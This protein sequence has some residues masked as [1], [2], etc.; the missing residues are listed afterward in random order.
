MYIMI[1]YIQNLNVISDK[2]LDRL[3]MINDYNTGFI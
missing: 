1:K 2:I 3:N